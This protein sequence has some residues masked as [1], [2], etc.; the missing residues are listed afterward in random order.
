MAPKSPKLL[1]SHFL[2]GYTEDNAYPINPCNLHDLKVNISNISADISYVAL[3]AVSTDVLRR[4]RLGMEHAISGAQFPNS[5]YQHRH[6][7]LTNSAIV[8]L[9][10]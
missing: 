5:S 1:P 9:A 10:V 2:W 7:E 8:A 4:S 3:L 6:I